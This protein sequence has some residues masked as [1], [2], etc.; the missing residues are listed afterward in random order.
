MLKYF[1]QVLDKNRE[2]CI[3]ILSFEHHKLGLYLSV[4]LKLGV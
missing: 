4:F 3:I 2:A 1:R